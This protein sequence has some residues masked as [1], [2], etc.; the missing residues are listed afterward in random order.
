MVA[1]LASSRDSKLRSHVSE[2]NQWTN[3]PT[4]LSRILLEDWDGV[5]SLVIARTATIIW[6]TCSS[7][8]STRSRRSERAERLQCQYWKKHGHYRHKP[9]MVSLTKVELAALSEGWGVWSAAV[10]EIHSISRSALLLHNHESRPHHVINHMTLSVI[11]NDAIHIMKALLI[12]NKSFVHY[13]LAY[14]SLSY[15][16]THTWFFHIPLYS[17]MFWDHTS[18]NSPCSI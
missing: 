13:W 8:N 6:V 17:L 11:F 2:F 5:A 1:R 18:T 3:H 14:W 7:D 4:V 16:M 12:T 15:D 9:F 10:V